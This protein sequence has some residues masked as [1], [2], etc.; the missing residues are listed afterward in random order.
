MENCIFSAICDRATGCDIGLFIKFVGLLVFTYNFIETWKMRA[1]VILKI[2][3]IFFVS[4]RVLELTDQTCRVSIPLNRR[5]RNHVGSLYF[6]ALAVGADLTAGLLAFRLIDKSQFKINFLFKDFRADFL[7]RCE[8]DTVFV[9][10]S[11]T[12]ITEAVKKAIESRERVNVSVPITAFTPSLLNDE[13]TGQFYL[14]LSM[15]SY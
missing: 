2:P 14:T 6:G 12:R 1:Y 11:G 3:L 10:D 15:K 5:T 9:C 8:A 7:K 4:P 13:P